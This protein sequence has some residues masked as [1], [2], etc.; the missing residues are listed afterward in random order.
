M[1]FD[2]SLIQDVQEDAPNGVTFEESEVI[3]ALTRVASMSTRFYSDYGTPVERA[4]ERQFRKLNPIPVKPPPT[5]WR[6][7]L[8]RLGI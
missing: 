6:G 2:P 4:A 7:F 8:A 5:G 1:K 3:E